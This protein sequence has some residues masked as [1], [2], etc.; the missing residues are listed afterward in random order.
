MKKKG[1]KIIISDKKDDERSVSLLESKDVPGGVVLLYAKNDKKTSILLTHEAAL[2]TA[3]LLYEYI[4][5][6]R[7]E[8]GK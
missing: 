1:L 3:K 7:M 2:A 5:K 8:E 6:T 4:E